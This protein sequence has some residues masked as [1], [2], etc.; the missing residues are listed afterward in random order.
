MGEVA[1]YTANQ[2]DS[3]FGL[4]EI[5]VTSE[6]SGVTNA[7]VRFRWVGNYSWGW[8][9]DDV[10]V[11]EGPACSVP[12][13]FRTIY[14]SFE[15]N[16]VTEIQVHLLGKLNGTEGFARYELVTNFFSNLYFPVIIT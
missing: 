9:V 5:D 15:I 13:G 8:A 7:K 3:S 4:E 12:T 2:D 10:V 14:R 16:W 6:L 11:E 1:Y